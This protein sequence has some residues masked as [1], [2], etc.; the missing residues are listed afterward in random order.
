VA[1][2]GEVVTEGG[3]PDKG[4]WARLSRAPG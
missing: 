2:S 4:P 1:G 3:D